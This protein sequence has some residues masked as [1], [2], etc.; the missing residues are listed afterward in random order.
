MAV[1]TIRLAGRGARQG[2]HHGL[3]AIALLLAVASL[4]RAAE[5]SSLVKARTLFNSANYEG[6]IA[7]ASV[8]RHEPTRPDAGAPIVARAHLERFR[9]TAD[10]QELAD[11]R[12]AL[13]A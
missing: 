11:A 8:A 1:R 3:L 4:A 13:R 7:A 10:V 12:E 5:S 2:L 6:A 9:Q